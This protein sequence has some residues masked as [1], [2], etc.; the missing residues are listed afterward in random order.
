[1]AWV[2]EFGGTTGALHSQDQNQE[3]L[4]E[5]TVIELGSLAQSF[6]NQVV[7]NLQLMENGG[8]WCHKEGNGCWEGVRES[9]LSSAEF[10]SQITQLVQSALLAADLFGR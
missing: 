6:G 10:F 8:L 3:S 5:V 9:G 4:I 1:M 7:G 2:A